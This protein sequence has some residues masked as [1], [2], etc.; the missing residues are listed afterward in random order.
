[1]ADPNCPQ[2]LRCFIGETKSFSVEV[3]D[4]NGGPYDLTGLGL[5]VKI[6]RDTGVTLQTIPNNQLT[7]ISN[8][9]AFTSTHANNSI[10]KHF[11]S[12]KRTDTNE[13]VA[14]GSYLVRKAALA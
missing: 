14:F 7:I 6:S 13:V 2:N 11:W 1:M 3:F 5:E 9:V 4:S 12:L 8:T 10:G